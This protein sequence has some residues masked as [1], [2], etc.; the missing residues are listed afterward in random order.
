MQIETKF[1]I[2]DVVKTEHMA[3]ID[4]MEYLVAGV[5]YQQNEYEGYIPSRGPKIIYALY[6][7]GQ[8]PMVYVKES[9][10]EF[11]R[12]A[13]QEEFKKAMNWARQAY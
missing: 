12:K 6:P 9:T 11:I 1:N 2:G 4:G 3:A 5:L 7:V 8:A 13:E 10:V